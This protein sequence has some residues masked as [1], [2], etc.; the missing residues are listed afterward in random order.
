MQV[1]QLE[2]KPR[3][4]MMFSV[5]HVEG[6]H[7][8]ILLSGIDIFLSYLTSVWNCVGYVVFSSSMIVSNEL[9]RMCEG[10]AVLH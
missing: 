5:C 7:V 9:R 1:A 6:V 10:A 2:Q 8:W 4:H 3:R